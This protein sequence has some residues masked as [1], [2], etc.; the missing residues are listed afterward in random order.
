MRT[1]GSIG[2]GL[3]SLFMV[4]ITPSLCSASSGVKDHA[5]PLG[6]N[7]RRTASLAW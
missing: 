3:S 6:P 2:R 4:A 1:W 7:S 5:V